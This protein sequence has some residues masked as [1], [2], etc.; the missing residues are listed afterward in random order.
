MVQVNDFQAGLAS[1]IVAYIRSKALPTGS[2]LPEHALSEHFN[3]SR[4]PVRA[5]L[6]LLA[7]QGVIEH[8]RNRGYFTRREAAG[9]GPATMPASDEEKIYLQIA[10]DRMRRQLPDQ[11][12]EAD[13]LR[14]YGT[15]RSVLSRALQRL[16]REGLVEKRPGRGWNFAQVL[17]SRQ[18]HDESFRFRLAIEPAA[19]LEPNF[20]LDEERAARCRV[21]HQALE[22][23]SLREISAIE[24]FEMNAEFHEL[25]AAASGN[26][27]FLQAV[28]QQNRLRRFVSYQWVYGPERAIDSCREHIAILDALESGDHLWASN[29][30]RRHLEISVSV[31]RQPQIEEPSAQSVAA[32]LIRFA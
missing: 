30:L 2:H 5:A 8:R 15:A 9:L 20:K 3:V 12:S 1:Q 23:G 32:R 17:N 27:F 21:A 31:V 13:L 28:Q 26:Q 18:A 29:L 16:V 10:S 24:L 11:V 14:R 22:S 6:S 7:G 19:V 25:V 4:T